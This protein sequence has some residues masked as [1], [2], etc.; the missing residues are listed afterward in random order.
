MDFDVVDF[1]GRK[2]GLLS[3]TVKITPYVGLRAFSALDVAPLEHFEDKATIRQELIGRGRL[4]ENLR[5]QHFLAYS[6]KDAERMNERVIVDALA[7][8]KFAVSSF[9]TYTNLDEIGRLT[10]DQSM[11]RFSTMNNGPEPHVQPRQYSRRRGRH[12]PPP[13]PDYPVPPPDEVT[14]EPIEIDLTPLTDEQCLLCVHT[15]KSFDIEGK[16]WGMF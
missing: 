8:H 9:E 3:R 1:D 14:E 6:D 7:Y 11:Q 15:V 16:K 5:G 2:C 12:Q 13:P 4:F 10:W